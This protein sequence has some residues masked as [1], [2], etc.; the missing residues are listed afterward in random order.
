MELLKLSNANNSSIIENI[1]VPFALDHAFYIYI[2]KQRNLDDHIKNIYIVLC[3]GRLLVHLL[4]RNLPVNIY[5][6]L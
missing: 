6:F 3:I 4:F 1:F 2:S 5:S